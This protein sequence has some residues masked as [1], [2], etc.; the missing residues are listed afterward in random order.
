MVGVSIA[1]ADRTRI[2]VALAEATAE[3]DG[4]IVC[5]VTRCASTYRDIAVGGS[6]AAALLLPMALVP[7]GFDPAWFPGVADSWE[8]AH[9][10]SRDVVIGR[11]LSAYAVLQAAVFVVAYLL[12]ATARGRR[13]A[14]PGAVRRQRVRAAAVRQF[15][16]Q[17]LDRADRRAGVLIFVALE[18]RRAE[19]V[20]GRRLLN[21]AP[22]EMWNDVGAALGRAL[23]ARQFAEGIEAAVTAC[24]AR[25][26]LRATGTA[27]RRP[28]PASRLILL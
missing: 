23:A 15:Q 14:T 9:L 12:L 2:E 7:L 21:D 5:I 22:I 4:D 1:P 6:A 10:A 20:V 25:M 27:D 26:P 18:E 3:R 24:G 13:W 28:A 16:A 17:G 8:G 11:A 19:I